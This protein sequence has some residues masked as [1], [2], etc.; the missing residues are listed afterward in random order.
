MNTL[1]TL[2]TEGR[3]TEAATFAQAMTVRFPSYGVGWKALG[4]AL[5][6]MG[7]S[8][9][10]LL[11]MQKAAALLP[12]DAEAHSNLGAI[13]QDLGQL[14]EA[15]TSCRRAIQIAPD[16]IEV[17]YN[18]GNALHAMGRLD[19]AESS[20]RRVLQIEPNIAEAHC[21][22]GIT[23]HDMG[24][25]NEAE[26]SYQ[27]ALQ[28]APDFAETHN[29]LGNT[30]KDMG[31]LAETEA[32]YRRAL[33]I[34]PD[35]AE[36]HYNLGITLSE[37]A[38]M[39]EAEASYKRALQI[40]P[41]YAEALSN[42]GSTLQE[43]GKLDEA[44]ANYR[45]ALQIKPDYAEALNNLGSTLQELG[46]LD[47]AE[48]LF[49]RALQ[50][51]PDFT[52]ALNNLALLFN[53]QGKASMALNTIKHSLQIKETAEAKSIFVACV[54]RL[55]F[56]NDDNE[57]RALMVRALT[58]PWGRPSEL[59]L[60]CI[61]LAKLNLDIGKCVSR[62]V[63]AWPV[64]LSA[65]D[66]FGSNSITTLAANSLLSAL[67]DSAPICD[68][69]MERF[70]TMARHAML[71]AAAKTP[72][73]N[74]GMDTTLSFYSALARQCFINEYVFSHGDDEIQQASVLRDA[75]IA[76]LEAKTPV[77]PL[78]LVAVAAYFP[79]YELPLAA[80]LLDAQWPNA[81]TALLTLQVREPAEELQLRASISHLTD[82]ED[83]VSL[84]VQ[85]QYEEN[86][87][88]RWT[89]MEPAGKAKNITG[90]LRQKFPLVSIKRHDT[91]NAI[92]M[93]IAGCGTGQHSIGTAQR[94]PGA[95]ILAI[96]LSISS[97]GYAKRKTHELGLTSIEYAQAD[98]LKLGSLG[99][100]FDVI[101]SVGVLHHL[102]D[103][104][105]GWQVLL[106]L[107][108]PGGFMKLGF[109]SE[110]ARRN[111]VRVRNLI[112]QRGYTETA[113]EIRRC[114]E[115]LI[116]L[117]KTANFGTTLKSSDFFSISN[118]RDL[119][120]HV[121][122]HRMTLTDIEAF[123]KKNN[124][125]FLGFE[126]ED[127]VLHAYRLRFPDDRAATNLSQW[128]IF[129]NENPDTFFGMYQF[130]IQKPV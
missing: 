106:S 11:P 4:V 103:P 51:K 114:R 87:Y 18:L 20:Y 102:A 70:L 95:R 41:D 123:L 71:D 120:I 130:W 118:C 125:A 92:D 47:E 88:P 69:E 34:K 28:I 110:V 1:A 19:E 33:Q 124:L 68:I 5:K 76:A 64:R 25:L 27:R 36:A 82:I 14:D 109:Y 96:D 79:L 98:I 32:R 13:F 85:N 78:S 81:I 107:L 119:L 126:I 16:F 90:Y 30:L 97:L 39:D 122:E 121:Q 116:A 128:Q 89:R 60:I 67:L 54:K 52:G 22:L 61:G 111:I 117:D 2:F 101:E 26:A 94:F 73:S 63:D 100:S 53:T 74:G 38:R 80:R 62:A 91:G 65:Q 40:R 12:H 83:K 24:R 10:A 15:V 86:P 58:E 127:D 50:I 45:R 55:R 3:Y 8:E 77:P 104:W 42:L 75:L 105:A 35:Y 56:T 108:H 112:T 99:R 9:D 72:A 113:N 49:K 66:L 7:R 57:I 44:E 46:K 37:L 84:L 43:L 129:E 17:H 31:R 59:A 115:D 48:T 6:N 23:L 93:L 29:N 21:N